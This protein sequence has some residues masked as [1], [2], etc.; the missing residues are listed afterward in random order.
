M[1]TSRYRQSGFSLIEIVIFIVIVGVAVSAIT[2]QFSQNVKESAQPILR[3]KAVAIA[4]SYFDRMQRVAW[5]DPE[6]DALGTETL[7][8]NYDDI[9]DFSQ[10]TGDSTTHSGYTIDIDVSNPAAD[11]ETIPL[12][13]VKEVTLD[14]AIN[15]TGETLTFTLYRVNY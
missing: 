13:D 12:A 7:I 11:W 3:H 9:T 15:A 4:H 6:G 10:I 5:Q 14:V 8:A 1:P 2:L